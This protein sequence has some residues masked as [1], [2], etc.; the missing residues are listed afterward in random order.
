MRR[1]IV[2]SQA[3]RPEYQQKWKIDRWCRKSRQ[4]Q[5]SWAIGKARM[6][7]PPPP[8]RRFVHNQRPSNSS[9]PK[10]SKRNPLTITIPAILEEVQSQWTNPES[11]PKSK[12]WEESSKLTIYLEFK[13]WHKHNRNWEIWRPWKLKMDIETTWAIWMVKKKWVRV[14]IWMT[15][16]ARSL[17]QVSSRAIMIRGCRVREARSWRSPMPRVRWL[18]LASKLQLK[19]KWPQRQ[20][21]RWLWSLNRT[22]NCKRA[23]KT[24]SIFNLR[25]LSSSA[26]LLTN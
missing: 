3:V 26:C 18:K 15:P 4:D 5:D 10:R 16:M 12:K 11:H 25:L 9:Q 24:I 20:T 14:V 23:P 21:G 8:N 7:P 17:L 6:R 13:V 22:A 2:D 19:M 1:T